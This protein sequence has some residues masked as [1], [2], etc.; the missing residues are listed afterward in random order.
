MSLFAERLHEHEI[1]FQS[2]REQ[3]DTFARITEVLIA[4]LRQ[5]GKICFMGNGGSA[6]DAQHLATELVGR[7]QKERPGIASI[8]FTTDTS[9]LTAVANDYGYDRIFARQ[10][11]ALC[12]PEDVVVGISTSGNSPNVLAGVVRARELGVTTVGLTGATGGALAKE[13]DHSL[14]VPQGK[15]ARIQEAHIFLGHT[16][17]EEIEEALA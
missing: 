7:F 2:L 12:K 17:C 5:G 16:W 1:M 14:I 13:A 9:L 4:S 8:A 15:A 3:E 11:E 10:I 6:G